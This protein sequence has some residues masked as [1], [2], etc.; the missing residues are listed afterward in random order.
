MW[1]RRYALVGGGGRGAVAV[2]SRGSDLRYTWSSTWKSGARHAGDHSWYLPWSNAA[3]AMVPCAKKGHRSVHLYHLVARAGA[4]EQGLFLG[5]QNLSALAY[6]QPADDYRSVPTTVMVR[7]AG[8]EQKTLSS[9]VP[10]GVRY[11]RPHRA[12]AGKVKPCARWR[13]RAI[14]IGGSVR[15]TR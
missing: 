7:M 10:A 15:D 8:G 5:T 13:R 2:C 6:V 4:Y 3:P 11:P 9:K 1:F 12:C 14:S